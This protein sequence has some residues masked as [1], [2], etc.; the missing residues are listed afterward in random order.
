MTMILIGVSLRGFYNENRC[1][2]IAFASVGYAYRPIQSFDGIL[3]R[4]V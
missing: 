4:S 1:M 3:K 2:V